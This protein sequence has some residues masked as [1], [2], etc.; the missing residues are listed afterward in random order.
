MNAVDVFCWIVIGGT[1]AIP[2]GM[3]IY[4]LFSIAKLSDDISDE[5]WREWNKMKYVIV[6]DTDQY[7]GCLVM[8]CGS[9]KEKAEKTLHRLLTDP[10][11][12]DKKMIEGHSN[13]RVEKVGNK[14]CWWED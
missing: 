1:I 6:G 3:F 8:S 14:D 9:S 11:E 2:V 7:K 4:S 5:Q 13:L 12:Y 10:D